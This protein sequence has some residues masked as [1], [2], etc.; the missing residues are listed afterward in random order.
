MQKDWLFIEEDHICNFRA[1]GVL[2]R[3]DRMFMQR[4]KDGTECAL[5]GGHVS[6]GETAAQALIREYKEE[7]GADIL[8]G[9]LLW[10]EETFWKWGERDAHTITF[11]FLI[12]LQDDA[13]IPDGVAA[14]QK[15]NCNVLLEWVALN[16]LPDLTVYPSFL[17]E[18]VKDISDHIEHFVRYE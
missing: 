18:K 10:V 13:D 17:A 12:S 9:R 15:D 4:E 1:A 11:Y 5:P 7:T 8:C 16:K 3:N 14:S 6:F 2:I